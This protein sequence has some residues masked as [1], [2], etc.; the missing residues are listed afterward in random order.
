MPARIRF[1]DLENGMRVYCRPE[2]GTNISGIGVRC[3]SAND[4]PGKRGLAHL[5][6]HVLARRSLKHS[7]QEVD[8]IIQK[9]M[10]GLGR[11]GKMRIET[12]RD[13]TFFG[14]D[15]LSNRKHLYI[16]FDMAARMV[17]DRV[18]DET[19]ICVEKAAAH[20]ESFLGGIDIEEL[21]FRGGL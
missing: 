19:D 11:S 4:P 12:W 16:C 6:E 15:S 9:Y 14:H 20:Q 18:F 17:H 1:F 21:F 13:A 2:Y 8:F 10:L 3:G 7:P 5:A